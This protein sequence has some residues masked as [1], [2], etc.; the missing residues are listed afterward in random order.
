MECHPLTRA[1]YREFLLISRALNIQKKQRD[2]IARLNMPIKFFLFSL[3]SSWQ[4]IV[5][6]QNPHPFKIRWFIDTLE[7]KS[8]IA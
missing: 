5:A 8:G 6:S 4:L 2:T 3:V 7:K 1:L